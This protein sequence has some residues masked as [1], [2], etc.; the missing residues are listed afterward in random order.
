MSI[1]VCGNWYFVVEF[2]IHRM[3]VSS[4]NRQKG[5]MALGSFSGFHSLIACTSNNNMCHNPKSQHMVL[6]YAKHG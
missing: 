1:F 4:E 3:K 2:K 6:L 5:I